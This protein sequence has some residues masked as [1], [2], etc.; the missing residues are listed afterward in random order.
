MDQAWNKLIKCLDLITDDFKEFNYDLHPGVTDKKI[1][2]LE[3]II[4]KQFPDDFK[5]FYKIHNGESTHS[6]G[7][8]KGEE[9]LSMERILE[10]WNV[11]KDLLESNSFIDDDDDDFVGDPDS[12][13]KDNWWNINWVPFT[14]D[15]NGNSICID[16]DPSDEGKY[17]Q[18]IRVW[19]DDPLRELLADSFTEWIQDY[20][21]Q[22]ENNE[23]TYS[24]DF[25][26]LVHKSDLEDWSEN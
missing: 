11:W 2:S 10:E 14:Y 15:G 5:A 21:S 17:G 25:G 7:I 9:F 20:V 3:N 26:V 1:I 18:I 13:I 12:G 6:N 4:K 8:M 19:H 22:L 16:L 24:E 23:F